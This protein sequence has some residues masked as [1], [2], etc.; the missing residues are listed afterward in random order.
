M[1]ADFLISLFNVVNFSFFFFVCVSV[2]VLLIA[3]TCVR[4]SVLCT[5][6][7]AYLEYPDYF[8]IRP[9]SMNQYVVYICKLYI[10]L[11]GSTT[12]VVHAFIA[13]I[14]ALVSISIVISFHTFFETCSQPLSGDV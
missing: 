12:L 5:C 10:W 9:F 13:N 1:T 6:V 2:Y 4:M 3:R 8:S 11:N 7:C 14:T